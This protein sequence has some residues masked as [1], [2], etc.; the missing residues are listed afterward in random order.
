[1][2]YIEK[3]ESR[4]DDLDDGD[5]DVLQGQAGLTASNFKEVSLRQND[6]TK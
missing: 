4:S 1:M 2:E 5:N 3:K 6:N